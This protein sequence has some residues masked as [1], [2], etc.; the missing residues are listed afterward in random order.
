MLHHVAGASTW[1][2]AHC[3][4]LLIEL[5]MDELVLV[6][7]LRAHDAT[8]TIDHA[9]LI[10]HLHL[11]WR[12]MCTIIH[13]RCLSHEIVDEQWLQLVAVLH[14]LVLTSQMWPLLILTHLVHHA[15]ATQMVLEHQ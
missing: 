12:N 5:L 11:L 8:S 3:A 2:R 1:H 15:E 6:H 7:L 9:I 13:V 4:D 14:A 10:L